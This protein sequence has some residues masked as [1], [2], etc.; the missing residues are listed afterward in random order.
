MRRLMALAALCMVPSVTSGQVGQVPASPPGPL[1]SMSPAVRATRDF[2]KAEGQG[3]VLPLAQ[4]TFRQEG[5]EQLC[6]DLGLKRG[7]G[8]LSS[9]FLTFARITTAEGKNIEERFKVPYDK[10]SQFKNKD[11]II[12]TGCT[13]SASRYQHVEDDR[14]QVR[15]RRPGRKATVFYINYPVAGAAYAMNIF[16]HS[17]GTVSSLNEDKPYEESVDDSE[18]EEEEEKLFFIGGDENG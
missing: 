5:A 9:T 1:P 16:G 14:L 11:F 12:E 4:A 17:N 7:P 18:G 8:A 15:I 10:Q 3:D 6:V 13:Q 2:L